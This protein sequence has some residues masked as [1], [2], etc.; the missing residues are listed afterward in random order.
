MTVLHPDKTW[1]TATEIADARLPDLPGTRQGVEA[2]AK[3]SGWREHPQLSRQR[4][5][6]GGGW[7]YSWELF[8]VAARRKLLKDASL[9]LPAEQPVKPALAD[10]HAY[11]E[12]LP[13]SVKAKA[14]HRHKVL[15]SVLEMERSGL[16]RFVAVDQVARSERV[17][18]RTIW[19]WFS[20]VGHA[21]RG[22]WLYYL[23]PRNRAAKRSD[24]K[25]TCSPEFMD[26]LKSLFLRLEAPTFAQ[27]YRDAVRLAK[28]HGWTLLPERTARRRLNQ[29]TP[30]GADLCP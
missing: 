23:A 29:E 21:D 17:S 1:W 9:T 20:M 3:R 19:N 22:D 27:C 25:A 10:L 28:A 4:D 2:E 7:E 5:G 26:R 18:D 16:T 15:L 12:S 13:D 6:K 14:R 24:P 8:P 11:Y 30:R